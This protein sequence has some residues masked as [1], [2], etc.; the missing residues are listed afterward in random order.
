VYLDNFDDHKVNVEEDEAN[1]LSCYWLLDPEAFAAFV[2]ETKPYF[3]K[4]AIEEFAKSQGIHPA[5]VVGRL[6]HEELVSYQHLGSLQIKVS[7]FLK[8]WIDVSAPP[9][10]T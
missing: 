4:T 8:D 2:A 9:I 10:N 7:P 1:Q 5:I 6:Q 3:S